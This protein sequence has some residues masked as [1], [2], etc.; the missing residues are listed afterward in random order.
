MNEEPAPMSEDHENLKKLARQL[1][2]DGQETVALEISAELYEERVKNIEK[3]Q[4]VAEEAINRANKLAANGDPK[5]EKMAERVKNAVENGFGQL[6]DFQLDPKAVRRSA[7]DDPFLQNSSGSFT[8]SSTSHNSLPPK[9]EHEPPTQKALPNAID[10][11]SQRGR[12][13]GSKNRP[14]A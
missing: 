13:K 6:A 9:A 10:S 1:L 8:D 11:T 2:K 3:A 12:P 14:K 5:F 7:E 4:R